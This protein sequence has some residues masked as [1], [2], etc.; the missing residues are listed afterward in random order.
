[1]S[2]DMIFDKDPVISLNYDSKIEEINEFKL[3]NE[4]NLYYIKN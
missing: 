4:S 1:M 3:E 2:K